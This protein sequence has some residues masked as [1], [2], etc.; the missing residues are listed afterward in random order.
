M[1]TA[2]VQRGV[3]RVWSVGPNEKVVGALTQTRRRRRL[4]FQEKK[5]QTPRASGPGSIPPP[6]AV[7]FV[8]RVVFPCTSLPTRL[9]TERFYMY[10]LLYPHVS[11]PNGF[12]IFFTH[13]SQYRTVLPSSLPTRLNT[14]RFYYLYLPAARVVCAASRAAL[15]A[16][17]SSS[18]DAI[19]TASRLLDSPPSKGASCPDS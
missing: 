7:A 15:P 19:C 13:T 1:R 17:P 8:T 4:Q 2:W 14:E 16:P 6:G 12:T 11:I 3:C 10:Y 18:R 5:A 9:N